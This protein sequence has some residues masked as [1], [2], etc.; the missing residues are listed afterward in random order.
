L[1]ANKAKALA[2]FTKGE[3][4]F[5]DRDLYVSCAGSDGK[6][7]AHI[8]STRIG[9][10]RNTQKDADGKPYG[11]EIQKVAREGAIAEVRYKFPRPGADKTPRP[12]VAFVTKVADQICLVGYYS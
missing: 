9:L 12:K 4:G 7:T 11:Q 10:D 2:Q 5:K 6:V 1:K 8:D 3:G